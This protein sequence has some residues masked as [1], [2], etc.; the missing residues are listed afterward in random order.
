MTGGGNYALTDTQMETLKS[1][2]REAVVE[3]LTKDDGYELVDD[4][5]PE[6]SRITAGSETIQPTGWSYEHWDEINYGRIEI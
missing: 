4:P 6:V 3:A 2:F 5:G 1:L